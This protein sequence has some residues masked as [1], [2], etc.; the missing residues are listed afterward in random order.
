MIQVIADATLLR[1]LIEIEVVDILPVLFWQIMVPP[2][3]I[4]DLQHINTPA[5]VR[6]WIA[7][8]PPWVVVQPPHS[9]VDSDLS[10]V[11]AG[12][13]EAILLAHEHQPALLVTDDRR[14]RRVAEA[15]GLRVVGTVW[16]LER[17]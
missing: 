14:A 7:S 9:A 17:A 15:R 16:V 5:P 6:T 3:V 4:H 12:E 10:R 2:A 8:P 1:Y 11:G 13:R